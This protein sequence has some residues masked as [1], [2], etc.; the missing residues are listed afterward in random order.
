MSKPVGLCAC[1][2]VAHITS[3][4]NQA[5]NRLKQTQRQRGSSLACHHNFGWMPR[6]GAWGSGGDAPPPGRLR[7]LSRGLNEQMMTMRGECPRSPLP[8]GASNGR[9]TGSRSFTQGR[10][11]REPTAPPC[12][13]TPGCFNRRRV[14]PVLQSQVQRKRSKGLLSLQSSSDDFSR[15]YP[16]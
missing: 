6:W 8:R 12:G 7:T 9:R 3:S 1:A 15:Q 5:V 10:L 13:G 4:V 14:C 16:C 11:L 2:C